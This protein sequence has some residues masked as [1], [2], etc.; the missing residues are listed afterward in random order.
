MFKNKEHILSDL[1]GLLCK[2]NVNV[3]DVIVETNIDVELYKPHTI[4][5]DVITIVT[6]ELFEKSI[7]IP[8]GT[9]PHYTCVKP[10]I[11]LMPKFIWEE[12]RFQAVKEAID[13]YMKAEKLVPKEWWEEYS[14]LGHKIQERRNKQ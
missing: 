9:P 11:G 5:R 4:K 3:V 6:E 10:P 7:P 13:R 2:R 8:E 14:E 12:K 1:Q